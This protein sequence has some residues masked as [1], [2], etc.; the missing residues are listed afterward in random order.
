[1]REAVSE[2]GIERN[3]E[4]YVTELRHASG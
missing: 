2:G 1:L 4:R 3:R